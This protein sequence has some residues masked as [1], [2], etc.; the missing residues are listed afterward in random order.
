MTDSRERHN[1]HSELKSPLDLPHRE[2]AED[3]RDRLADQ[4]RR[5]RAEAMERDAKSLEVAAENSRH[6]FES[7]RGKLERDMAQEVGREMRGQFYRDVSAA[8]DRHPEPTRP[9]APHGFTGREKAEVLRHMADQIEKAQNPVERAQ[10][11]VAERD[12]FRGQFFQQEPAKPTPS[13][14]ERWTQRAE[15]ERAAM[16]ERGGRGQQQ[17]QEQERER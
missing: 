13:M 8:L 7:M 5:E 15:Q 17:E 3:L 9:D 11:R 2:K 12:A 14:V 10:D 1:W 4:Q 16:R 6:F